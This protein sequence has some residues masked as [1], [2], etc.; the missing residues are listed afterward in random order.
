M[1]L[2]SLFRIFC[3]SLFS[4]PSYI[5]LCI[6]FLNFRVFLVL[7]PSENTSSFS[8]LSFPQS[9][10]SHFRY[11]Y[12]F[13]SVLNPRS[14]VSYSPPFSRSGTSL[15]QVFSSQVVTG[16]YGRRSCHRTPAPPSSRPLPQT[17]RRKTRSITPTVT[18]TRQSLA[19][20][21]SGKADKLDLNFLGTARQTFSV[22]GES[23]VIFR[24]HWK[25]TERRP[26]GHEAT[27][28]GV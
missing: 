21:T 12:L 1:F 26:T 13:I 2:S 16:L 8:S 20:K 4:F 28:K 9:A 15:L 7:S 6:F 18:S 25:V 3:S 14:H 17:R 5:L 22:G 11:S 10:T 27:L 23:E 24:P 19:I